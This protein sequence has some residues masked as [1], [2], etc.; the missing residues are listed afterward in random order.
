MQR[1]AD[2]LNKTEQ[3]LKDEDVTKDIEF[4]EKYAKEIDTTNILIA[5]KHHKIK[6]NN[7][8]LHLVNNDI[9]KYET[10]LNGTNSLLE[11]CS[12]SRC[13]LTQ[14]RRKSTSARTSPTT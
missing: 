5:K 12:K 11:E 13:G 8:T 3:L 4:T 9:F 10:Q 1:R 2:H 14:T 6:D 7:E